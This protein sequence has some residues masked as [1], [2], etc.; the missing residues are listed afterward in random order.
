MTNNAKTFSV[1]R[2][3]SEKPRVFISYS[4]KD[5]N[6][7]M[8]L[9]N[10]LNAH[11][12]DAFLDRSDILPGEDWRKRLEGL[13]LAA[14]AVVF[15]ISPDSVD[16]WDI[17]PP[18]EATCAWEIRRTVELG[19]QLVPILWRALGDATAPPELVK[20]NWV[21]FEAY[22]RSGLADE[23]EFT[24]AMDRLEISLRL[25]QLLWMREHTKWIA[26]AAEWDKSDP[27]RPEGKLL[28][29]ADIA[30]IK[31]WI[32]R[33][34]VGQNIPKVVIE[35]LSQSSEKEQRDIDR[36]RRTAGRAFVKPVLQALHDGVTEQRQPARCSLMTSVLT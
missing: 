27:V 28:R 10:A 20:P 2:A 24:T 15:V 12:Y 13:I 30:D 32:A 9:R 14:D 29:T 33:K 22:Q 3:N 21:S 36:L 4:R 19:K 17:P 35:Y 1:T 5:G 34:P 16:R 25:P 7:A 26:R 11:T 23:Q 6:F 31:A 18:H 8:K